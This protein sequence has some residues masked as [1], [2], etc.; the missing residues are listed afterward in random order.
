VFGTCDLWSVHGSSKEIGARR[1]LIIQRELQGGDSVITN[2]LEWERVIL[3]DLCDTKHRPRSSP[4]DRLPEE[5]PRTGHTC[6]VQI[7]P[8]YRTHTHTHTH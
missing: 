3:C 2:G 1:V 7:N 6:Q 8:S 5:R 4:C